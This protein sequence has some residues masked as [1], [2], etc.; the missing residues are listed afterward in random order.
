MH[1]G[2]RD[3]GVSGAKKGKKVTPAVRRVPGGTPVRRG[4]RDPKVIPES[5]ES[6]DLR[7]QKATP[8][9][10]VNGAPK[11]IPGHGECRDPKARRGRRVRR[12]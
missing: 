11:V 1:R 2:Y 8:G 7:G 3:P 5:V 6:P 4:H 10:R 9:H 12:G